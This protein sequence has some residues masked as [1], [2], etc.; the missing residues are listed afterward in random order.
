M[1]WWRSS[2]LTAKS[3]EQRLCLVPAARE[4]TDKSKSSECKLHHEVTFLIHL[5]TNVQSAI[6]INTPKITFSSWIT[7]WCL[8]ALSTIT[9]IHQSSC[10]ECQYSAEKKLIVLLMAFHRLFLAPSSNTGHTLLRKWPEPT[11]YQYVWQRVTRRL[12]TLRGKLQQKSLSPVYHSL[13]GR[14]C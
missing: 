2:W 4:L 6:V 12:R 11:I 10:R 3:K 8:W 5:S 1:G 14:T 13:H 9:A 7:R